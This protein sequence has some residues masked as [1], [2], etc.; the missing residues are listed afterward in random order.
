M[1]K[2]MFEVAILFIIFNM[3]TKWAYTT[4]KHIPLHYVAFAL[5]KLAKNAEIDLKKFNKL[6][7]QVDGQQN[8]ALD[9]EFSRL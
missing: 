1:V 4:K 5:K 8:S 3:A 6:D 9:T 2:F 7:V